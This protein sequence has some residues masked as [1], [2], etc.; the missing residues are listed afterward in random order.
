MY[1][2]WLKLNLFVCLS[3]IEARCTNR[4]YGVL[5]MF[6]VAIKHLLEVIACSH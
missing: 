2:P 1:F 3:Y 5:G 6:D 4:C